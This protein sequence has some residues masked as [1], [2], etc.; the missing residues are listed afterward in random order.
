VSSTKASTVI[1]V[2]DKTFSMFGVPAILRTDN[3]PPFQSHEFKQFST[4]LGFKHHHSTPLWPQGNSIAERFM[5]PLNKLIQTSKL[6]GKCLKQELCK[7]LRN[8]RATPHLSTGKPP[9]ELLFG[10]K[11]TINIPE[12]DE[13]T[14]VDD[15]VVQKDRQTKINNKHFYDKHFCNKGEPYDLNIGDKVLVKQT[16]NTKYDTFYNPKPMVIVERKENMITAKRG[17]QLI[18]RNGSQF[19]PVNIDA[20]VVDNS[21]QS[22]SEELNENK[23]NES[24]SVD[25][26]IPQLPVQTSPTQPATNRPRRNIMK[27]ARFKD[28]LC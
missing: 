16:K 25:A 20:E 28:F 2:F 7:F 8:Y 17:D 5:K 26:M 13:K 14:F 3:G 4:Y 22:D 23:E 12:V 9:A 27:P 11:F 18:T 21:D 1:P 6:E 19:I 10:R 24:D 15:S